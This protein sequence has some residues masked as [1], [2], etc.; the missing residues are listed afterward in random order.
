M[1]KYSLV[2]IENFSITKTIL[3]TSKK[4]A[5]T[6]LEDLGYDCINDHWLYSEKEVKD[7][8]KHLSK[9]TRVIF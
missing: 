6:K 9:F 8:N 5:Q 4:D 2:S 3:A 1:K 7:L